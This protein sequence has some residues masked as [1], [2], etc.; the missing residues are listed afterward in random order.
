MK[1][2]G[3]G[4]KFIAKLEG[5]K[6]STRDPNGLAKLDAGQGIVGNQPSSKRQATSYKLDKS[7]AVGYYRIRK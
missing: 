2:A 3:S 6:L 4:V 1:H 5:H 7:Q